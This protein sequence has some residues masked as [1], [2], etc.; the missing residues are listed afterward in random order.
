MP[1]PHGCNKRVEQDHSLPSYKTCKYMSSEDIQKG[2]LNDKH[3]P[4]KNSEAL[5][6]S[7]QTLP[8]TSGIL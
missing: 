1:G 8:N 2:L 7:R 5:P 3:A 6:S 4:K